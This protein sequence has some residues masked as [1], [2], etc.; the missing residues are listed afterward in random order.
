MGPA[1]LEDL[2][3]AFAKL[4]GIGRVTAQRLALYVV[5]RPRDEAEQLAHAL[6][7]VK[8]GIKKCSECFNF[9]ELSS[10]LC[11]VC[12]DERRDRLCICVVEE[13]SDVLALEANQIHR[14]VFHVLGGV[15]SPLE[16]ISPDDL[17]ITELVERVQREQTREVIL[18]LNAGPEGDA[19]ANYLH[20]LLSAQTRVSRPARGLP[21]G[22]D[23][24]LA[25]RVTLTHA[26]AGRSPL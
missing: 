1:P 13:A 16:G 14:G 4:P 11:A 18:A 5:K 25:D 20:Q 2:I 9:T 3:M 15:L 24:D 10:E 12:R 7:G 26:F 6:V 19:T 22:A 8:D 17:R 23:L 21:V